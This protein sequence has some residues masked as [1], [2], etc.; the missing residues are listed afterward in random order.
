[1]PLDPNRITQVERPAGAIE[2]MTDEI[3]YRAAAKSPK[4]APLHRGVRGVIRAR[5]ARPEPQVP[6]ESGRHWRGFRRASCQR[7]VPSAGSYPGMDLPHRTDCIGPN[8]FTG[9]P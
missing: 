8:P 7:L 4:I 9:L 5:L 1:M 3:A 6:I 2:I